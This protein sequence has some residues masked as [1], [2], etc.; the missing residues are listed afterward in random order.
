MVKHT[1]SV[2]SIIPPAKRPRKGRY[3]NI[4]SP[5]KSDR[6]G[7]TMEL[8]AQWSGR[9]LECKLSLTVANAGN[10]RSDIDNILKTTMDSLQEAGIVK[11]DKQIRSVK[12]VEG[13]ELTL[14]QLEE[15]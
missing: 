11:N 6:A 5:N 2:K 8:R 14:L 9:P 1:F 12:Y 7:L 15:I 3:G 13:A 4:Y 10:P